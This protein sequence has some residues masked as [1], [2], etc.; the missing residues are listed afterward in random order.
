MAVGNNQVPPG[1]KKIFEEQES[2]FYTNATTQRRNA[3][4]STSEIPIQNKNLWLE[5]PDVICVFIDMKGSTR[6]S[7]STDPKSTASCYQLFTETTIRILYELDTPYIDVK[8]DGVFGIFNDKDSYKALV[9]AVSMKTFCEKT[10]IPLVEKKT[11]KKLGVH[12]GIDRKS[13]LVRKFGLKA[14]GRSDRQNEVWTGKPVNMAVKLSSLSKDNEIVVSERF[15]EKLKDDRALYSCGCNDG[16]P[17]GTKALLWSS[18][19]VTQYQMFDFSKAY[20]LKSRWCEIHGAES[21]NGL[22][23]L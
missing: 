22:L 5:I 6:L 15:Y 19:D 20:V 17:S 1:I 12:I 14:V 18:L 3:V 21:M 16:K 7:I 8:G 2:V 23:D 10:F 11:G 4:P 13:V 9:S